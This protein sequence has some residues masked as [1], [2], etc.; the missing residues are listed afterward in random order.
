MQITLSIT[1]MSLKEQAG[2]ARRLRQL[3]ALP[4]VQTVESIEQH[5]TQLIERELTTAADEEESERIQ[6]FTEAGRV[7][8]QLPEEDQAE[9]VE[10]LRAKAILRGVDANGLGG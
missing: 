5:Y 8:A 3:N 7:L 10:A 9:L 4:G 2:L 1:D 6:Q